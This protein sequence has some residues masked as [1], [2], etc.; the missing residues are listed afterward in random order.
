MIKVAECIKIWRSSS[1][2]STYAELP[3][4]CDARDMLVVW[5]R[6]GAGGGGISEGE[7]EGEA[8]LM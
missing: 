1:L 5:W 6:R 7:G 3:T 8:A 4:K 2:F